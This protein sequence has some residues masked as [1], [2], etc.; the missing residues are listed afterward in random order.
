MKKTSTPPQNWKPY[1]KNFRKVKVMVVG[2]VMHDVFIWGR[3]RRISP[4]APVPV[5]EV[6]RETSL[7]GGSAN[8]VNNVVALG[9]KA[10]LAGVIGRDRPGDEVIKELDRIG[11][12]RS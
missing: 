10:Y 12:D 7:L 9:A 6:T 1:L 3:V 2:D 5:V 4:E 8:V 11:A